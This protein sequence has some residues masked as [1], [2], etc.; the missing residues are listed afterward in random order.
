M[1]TRYESTNLFHFTKTIVLTIV[2]LKDNN[3]FICLCKVKKGLRD[4]SNA[5]GPIHFS[6][7]CDVIE[8][9]DK[10]FIIVAAITMASII[11]TNLQ[12]L[13]QK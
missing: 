12:R 5:F 2:I 13:R 11:K 8:V 1:F 6:G 9:R 4:Q 10:S 3:V 7:A